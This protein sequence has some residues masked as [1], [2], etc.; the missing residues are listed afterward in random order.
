[1]A[2][3]FH[4]EIVMTLHSQRTYSYRVLKRNT[5]IIYEL[6]ISWD[7]SISPTFSGENST[8]CAASTFLDVPS[9]IADPSQKPG[10]PP[11]SRVRLDA[12]TLVP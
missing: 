6:D 10:S 11:P 9:P 12:C 8:R 1:M 2:E 3:M 7:P 5:Y 4:L